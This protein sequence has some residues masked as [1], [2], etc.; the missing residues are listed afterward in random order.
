MAKGYPVFENDRLHVFFHDHWITLLIFVFLATFAWVRNA[1]HRR[2]VR[3]TRALYN[4]REFYAAVRE[5]YSLSN[6]LSISLFL[7]YLF[8]VSLFLYQTNH[9][10]GFMQEQGHP[11]LFY[12]QILGVILL[13]FIVKVLIISF[14]SY[15]FLGKASASSD[16]IFN[17]YLTDVLSALVLLPIVIFL[18]YLSL[19]SPRLW[20]NG[21]LFLLTVLFLFRILRYF[22]IG[23][24]DAKVSK[25]YFFTYLCTVEVAPL[26]I[27]FKILLGYSAF[28]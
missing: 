1:H 9:F 7:L 4:I 12:S 13:V 8:A 23:S 17:I 6:S 20:I 27:G 16:Y 24:S 21:G 11:L 10:F 14:L 26:L 5:E 19:F 25:L 28:R 2:F 18:A 3:M 22:N 15:V